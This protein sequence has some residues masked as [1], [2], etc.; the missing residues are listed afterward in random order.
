MCRKKPGNKTAGSKNKPEKGK[1]IKRRNNNNKKTAGRSPALLESEQMSNTNLRNYSFKGG[2]ISLNYFVE[3]FMPQGIVKNN[4]SMSWQ[5]ESYQ[6]H[7]HPRVT[8]CIQSSTS[9][10][11]NIRGLTL[12]GHEANFNKIIQPITKQT[13][14]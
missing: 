3:K 7:S 10:R 9:L 12:M 8:G 4:R 5:S 11:S 2:R 13:S 1:K 14:K 6:N